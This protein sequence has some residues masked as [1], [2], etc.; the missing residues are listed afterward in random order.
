MDT[1]N[2][3]R[4]AVVQGR[5]MDPIFA[6]FNRLI[7]FTRL[8]FSSEEHLMEQCGYPGLEEHKAEHV[9]MLGQ[10]RAAAARLQRGEA[11]AIHPMLSRLRE[12]YLSHIEGQD[13][14]YGPWLNERG[15]Y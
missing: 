13:Q 15:V 9:R 4:L 5:G 8:H 3:L 10:L 14:L 1:M 11:P 6:V 12:G 7:E 2:E